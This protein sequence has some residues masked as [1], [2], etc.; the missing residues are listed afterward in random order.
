MIALS[1]RYGK[2]ENSRTSSCK[3]ETKYSMERFDKEYDQYRAFLVRTGQDLS[4]REH[5]VAHELDEHEIVL[6]KIVNGS[7][8]RKGLGREALNR[9]NEVAY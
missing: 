8:D 7:A 4:S 1:S 2:G 5:Q 6:G 3:P 9:S